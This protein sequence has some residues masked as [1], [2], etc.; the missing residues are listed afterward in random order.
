LPLCPA[1][2][3]GGG[4]GGQDPNKTTGKIE[5]ASAITLQYDEILKWMKGLRLCSLHPISAKVP[6]FFTVLYIY[7]LGFLKMALALLP[8]ILAGLSL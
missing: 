4:E 6:D 5:L 7:Y 2:S 1:V 8:A 3:T